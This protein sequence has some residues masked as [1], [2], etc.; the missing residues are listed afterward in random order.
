MELSLTRCLGK[1]E[2][3]LFLF[4]WVYINNHEK[5]A[6]KFSPMVSSYI[7]HVKQMSW[8]RW[9]LLWP[10]WKR[11]RCVPCLANVSSCTVQG[12]GSHSSDFEHLTKAFPSTWKVSHREPATIYSSYSLFPSLT[13]SLLP[14]SLSPFPEWTISQGDGKSQVALCSGHYQ[15]KS[16]ILATSFPTSPQLAGGE[17]TYLALRLEDVTQ[18]S[19]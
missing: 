9:G 8:K 6:R 13:P 5:A 14:K 15:M 10:D 17:E 4:F 7:I 2:S 19:T 18:D 11:K 12:S 1:T 3:L 16:R